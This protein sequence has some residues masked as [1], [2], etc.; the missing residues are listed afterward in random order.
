MASFGFSPSPLMAAEPNTER[1]PVLVKPPGGPR[2]PSRSPSRAANSSTTSNPV[3]G[4]ASRV[5]PG[6]GIDS[7]VRKFVPSEQLPAGSAV[8]FPVDI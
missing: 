6:A 1:A 5:R 7:G 8:A 2:P 3:L 4:P